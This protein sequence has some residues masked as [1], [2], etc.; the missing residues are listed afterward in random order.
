MGFF[1]QKLGFN[2]FSLLGWSDGG[3]SS[4]I[5]AGKYPQSVEKLVIWGANAYVLQEDINSYESK[6]YIHGIKRTIHSSFNQKYEIFL[7]GQKKPKDHW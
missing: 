1:Q 5:L 3:I 2:K 4:M 6:L 7:N